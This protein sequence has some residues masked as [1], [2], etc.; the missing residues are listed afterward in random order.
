MRDIDVVIVG[1]GAM[2]SASAWQLARRGAEVMLLEQFEPGH[3]RGGS[4][5]SSRIVRL[6]YT[7]P[8]YIELT[9]TAMAHWDELED[10][11]DERLLVG[12]GV[13]DHGDPPTVQALAAAMEIAG[14]PAEWLSARE[15]ARRWPGLE[16][17]GD[18]LHQ[19]RGGRV[20]ADN[21]VAAMQRL[22]IKHGAEMRHG[23]RVEAVQPQ[24]DRV[25]VRTASDTMYA[26][27]VVVAAGSWS[28]GVL[29]GVVAMPH[30]TV[31]LEQP[32]H[33][34]PR[35]WSV[36][37]PSFIHHQADA[38]TRTGMSPRGTYGLASPDGVKVGFHGTGPVIDPD[39]GRDVDP[40]ALR[41]VQEYVRRWVPGADAD[42]AE[43]APCLYD[44]TDSS[45]FVIDQVRNV[46]VAAGFSGHGF[47]FTPLIGRLIAELVLE[48]RLPHDRFRLR[49]V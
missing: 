35:D 39:A 48:R 38:T 8:F 28:P 26:K 31:S 49:Q 34:Q 9:A 17:D 24:S 47:K 30:L 2:G 20:H 25:E 11:A 45:D 22:A 18:V 42:T 32:V 3:A 27:Q 23:V 15:A 43:A 44:I 13:I 4:H 14:Y 16:F 29:A 1:G 6:A 10:E 19:H 37:W 41:E 40:A 5:G 21:A 12:T 36:P 46:T 7:D 33:F